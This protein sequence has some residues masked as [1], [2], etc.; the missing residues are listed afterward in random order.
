LS[1]QVYTVYTVL[2]GLVRAFATGDI[3][4]MGWLV[5]LRPC[6][7]GGREVKEVKAH[8]RPFP[9][10]GRGK[11]KGLSSAPPVNGMEARRR[12]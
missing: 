7:C 1:E 4:E 5:S 9:H 6:L 11:K 8:P 3:L 2:G 12:G 10:A